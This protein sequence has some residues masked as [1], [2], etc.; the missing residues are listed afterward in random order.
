MEY[1]D[2]QIELFLDDVY[3]MTTNS[4]YGKREITN[5]Y[6][7]LFNPVSNEFYSANRQQLL[8]THPVS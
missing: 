3:R 2:Q 7:E 6:L 8:W 4:V 1:L 5:K